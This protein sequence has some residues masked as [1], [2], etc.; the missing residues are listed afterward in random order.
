MKIIF[1]GTS[2]FVASI[3]E[4]LFH[5]Y[6]VI[7]IV[8]AP[9]TKDRKGNSIPSPI[10]KH[11][12]KLLDEDNKKPSSS[13]IFSALSRFSAIPKHAIALEVVE[14]NASPFCSTAA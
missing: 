9:D 13:A 3:L 12:Q 14:Y 4:N 11:Y 10:K 8:T 2:S 5:R 1:F 6:D 7:A